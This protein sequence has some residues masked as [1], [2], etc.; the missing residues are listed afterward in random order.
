MTSTSYGYG[1]VRFLVDPIVPVYVPPPAPPVFALPFARCKS[2][3]VEPLRNPSLS[4]VELS[5]PL[6]TNDN[7]GHSSVAGDMNSDVGEDVLAERRRVEKGSD[8][9]DGSDGSR[10]GESKDDRE[11][12]RVRILGLKK[13]FPGRGG[14]PKSPCRRC[15]WASMNMNVWG[16]W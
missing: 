13:V 16:C 6:L 7:D 12:L 1:L 3:E 5:E 14:A 11:A 9:S 4:G 8:R 10:A 15:I 2:E